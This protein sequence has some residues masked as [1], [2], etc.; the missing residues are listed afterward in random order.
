M[1]LIYGHCQAR[2]LLMRAVSYADAYRLC[3]LRDS[4]GRRNT[5]MSAGPRDQRP[6]CLS[7]RWYKR[8]LGSSVSD[9]LCLPISAASDQLRGLFSMVGE[10]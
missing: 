9:E 3:G 7:C 5:G 1:L 8:R 10:Q 6:D 2:V 4:T